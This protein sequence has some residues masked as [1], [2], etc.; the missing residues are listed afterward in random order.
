MKPDEFSIPRKH[1]QV[2]KLRHEGLTHCV[3]NIICYH[4]HVE[5]G[6]SFCWALTVSQRINTFLT[7]CGRGELRPG[8]LHRVFACAPMEKIKVCWWNQQMHPLPHPPN[9]PVNSLFRAAASSQAREGTSHVEGRLGLLF[10]SWINTQCVHAF[11]ELKETFPTLSEFPFTV[12]TVWHLKLRCHTQISSLR[13]EAVQGFLLV[14]GLKLDVETTFIAP[15][16]EPGSTWLPRSAS[17]HSTQ[18]HVSVIWHQH[19]TANYTTH[20]G[21][22]SHNPP[23]FCHSIRFGVNAAHIQ[24]IA[25]P[26]F[27]SKDADWCGHI[28]TRW[29]Q[30]DWSFSDASVRIQTLNLSKV[31]PVSGS[32]LWATR[33]SA[34]CLL[35]SRSHEITSASCIK[36]PVASALPWNLGQLLQAVSVTLTSPCDTTTSPCY[37]V[38]G[39]GVHG[40]AAGQNSLL[41]EHTKGRF[42]AGWGKKG[43]S[44]SMQH[45]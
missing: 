14:Q 43:L 25:P 19:N 28:L 35:S 32:D 15:E 27:F 37:R 26:S 7:G 4:L 44:F 45:K 10:K 31:R 12:G 33:H 20:C 18:S 38:K 13:V 2:Q 11:M 9:W 41:G 39:C 24:A 17:C 8:H 5:L 21:S 16:V 3:N 6:P 36:H 34:L 1:Q 30:W 23:S 29:K 42:P 40:S 22:R